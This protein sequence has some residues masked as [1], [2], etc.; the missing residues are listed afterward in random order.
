MM[1]FNKI[2]IS[3]VLLIFLTMSGMIYGQDNN[4]ESAKALSEMKLEDLLNLEVTTASKKAE[5]TSDASGIIST[6][7]SEE[8]KYFGANNLNDVLERATS[9]Q[10]LGSHLF[11]N[12]ISVMRGDLRTHYDN[13]VLI[14]INGRPI[15]EGVMGGLNSPIYTSFPVDMIDR[16]EIIRGPGSVLYG[17]N[18]FVGVI[19]IITKRDEKNSS[20]SVKTTGG[21]FGTFNGTITGSVVKEDFKAKVGVKLENINGWDFQAVT[22]RPGSPNLPIDKKWGQKNIGIVTDLAYKGL[23]FS[24]FYAK[25]TQDIL[26]ILPYATFAGKNKDDRLFLNLGYTYKLS[27]TWDASLNV[28]HDGTKLTLNDEAAIPPDKHSCADYLGE[29]TVGGE[30][31]DNLNLIVGGVLDS[32]NKNVVGPTDAIKNPYH[33]IQLSAYVQTDYRPVDELKLIIGAQMN[34][35]EHKNWDMVPRFG[36][37]YNF[38]KEMGLKTLY[39]QAFRSPW[40]VEQLL[41]NPSVVGNPDLESEKIGT[42]DIQFFYASKKTEASVTYYNSK[43]TN[44]ISR[45]PVPGQPGVVTYVNQGDLHMNGFEFEGKASVSSNVFITGSATIQNNADENTVPVYIPSFM[46]KIGS[47]VNLNK[48]LTVGVFNTYF[49]KP[50]GNNGAAVNPEAK[51]VDLVSI[52]VNYKLPVSLPLEFNV[53]VQNLLNSDYYYPEFGRSWVN[54]LP[55]QPGTGIYGSLGLNL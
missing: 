23:T 38:T 21:S 53:Y 36:A 6:I 13:H 31:I 46:G 2:M 19:N 26:G 55:L 50:K 25:N 40:P 27:R 5:K 49:G 35:P 45:L 28:S 47:F 44:S 18:A 43:Y 20:L 24:G 16:I 7:T 9:I 3:T 51:A 29:L 33:Q 22:A 8:I 10:S 37:I 54:T 42:L 39:S 48:K 1:N 12:N 4:M 52:N 41:A 15:R 34:K 14:L 32:R 30:V 17:S 11:P